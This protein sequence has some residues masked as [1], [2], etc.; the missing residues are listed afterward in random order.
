MRLLQVSR[1]FSYHRRGGR[2]RAAPL[3][4]P[5]SQALSEGPVGHHLPHRM[6]SLH[7]VPLPKL[8][9]LK[10][11]PERCSNRG[12]RTRRA[13]ARTK[14]LPWAGSAL[15]SHVW[16]LKAAGTVP[17]H[18]ARL[19]ARPAT[20]YRNRSLCHYETPG[21]EGARP[22]LS[23]TDTQT[24]TEGRGERCLLPTTR[25]HREKGITGWVGSL[26][27]VTR[28]TSLVHQRGLLG[29]GYE[30]FVTLCAITRS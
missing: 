18:P 3:P 13:A 27:G 29:Q 28:P 19:P 8:N 17:R 7:P 26:R 9:L 22:R 15:A 20:T 6:T 24:T 4:P 2:P 25:Q 5:H 11:K 12:R 30:P 23:N 14:A 16:H 1:L 21:A 10:F